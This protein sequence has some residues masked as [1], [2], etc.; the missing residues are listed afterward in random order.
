MFLAQ[1]LPMVNA[2]ALHPPSRT[3]LEFVLSTHLC[4]LDCRSRLLSQFPW[5]QSSHLLCVSRFVCIILFILNLC[6]SNHPGKLTKIGSELEKRLRN[7]CRKARSGNL[8]SR[9]WV[10][11]W[12]IIC[13]C[14]SVSKFSPD[15]L[16]HLP[17]PCNRMSAW[18]SS[19]LAISYDFRGNDTRCYSNW[20]RGYSQSCQCG[21]SFVTFLFL[22][23][24]IYYSSLHGRHLQMDI[25]L[26]QTARWQKA[27]SQLFKS[28]PPWVV[29]RSKIQK[30]KIGTPAAIVSTT[31]NVQI[32]C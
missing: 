15:Y 31:L 16:G 22:H 21:R 28:L 18:H 6:R 11:V 12:L 24:F 5:T 23:Q 1:V 17:V 2:S 4:S 25:S 27:T 30:L 7:E 14:L 9:A 19:T 13:R 26:V 3:A 20:F 29:V 8:R 32:L 10:F